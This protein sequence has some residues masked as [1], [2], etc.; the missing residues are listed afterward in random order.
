MTGF[1]TIVT[2]TLLDGAIQSGQELIVLPEGLHA[3][4]RGLQNHKEKVEIAYPGS[5]VAVN[6]SNINTQQIKR[7]DVLAAPT[8]YKSTKRLTAHIRLLKDLSTPI[9]HDDSVKIFVGTQEVV[10]RIRLLGLNRIKPGGFGWIQMEAEDPIVTFAGDKFILR[11]PSP[12]E[13]IGGGK[14]IEI[15]MVKRYKRF[16]QKIVQHLEALLLGDPQEIVLNICKLE[17]CIT[18]INMQKKAGLESNTFSETLAQLL[19]GHAVIELSQAA[20]GNGPYNLRRMK[21]TRSNRRLY[22]T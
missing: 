22:I 10:A 15:D 16:D 13:T 5:R 11:R 2:G 21:L 7:G 18:L 20:E 8:F 19:A 17:R 6:L 1:G 14:I 12:G 3:R 4:I 9:K